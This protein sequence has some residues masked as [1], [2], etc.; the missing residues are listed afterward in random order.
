[1]PNTAFLNWI[2]PTIAATYL[3]GSTCSVLI[4]EETSDRAVRFFIANQQ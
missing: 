1:M 3:L 4:S 2:N